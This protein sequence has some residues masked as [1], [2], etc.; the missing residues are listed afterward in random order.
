MDADLWLEEDVYYQKKEL[1]A[2]GR[3]VH[4]NDFVVE[5]CRKEEPIKSSSKQKCNE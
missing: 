1:N 2:G 5:E 3:P 4:L